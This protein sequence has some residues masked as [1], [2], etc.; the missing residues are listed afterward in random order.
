ML[1]ETRQAARGSEERPVGFEVYPKGSAPIATVPSVTIQKRGLI[2][3]NRAAFAMLK[4]PEAVELMW[5]KER[6]LVGLRSVPIDSPNAYPVR[7]QA[8]NSD[9][10][11]LLI[12]GNLFTRYIGLDTEEAHRWI[13]RM[14]D[15]IL[16]IDLSTPGAKV[17][18]NRRAAM[19]TT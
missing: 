6:Q 13:P 10:G 18:S 5:D 3:M 15:E 19:A 11:P 7:P 1:V 12:A 8:S 9:K 17:H 16:V 2:S 14:E 4:E